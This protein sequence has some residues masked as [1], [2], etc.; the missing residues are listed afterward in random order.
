[1]GYTLAVI[2]RGVGMRP[3]E[4]EVANRRLAGAESFT[5]APSKYLGHYVAGKLAARQGIAVTL[6]GTGSEGAAPLVPATDGGVTATI[7]IPAELVTAA[8]PRPTE[9]PPTPHQEP[10]PAPQE[11]TRTTA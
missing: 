1:M 11:P 10:A 8:P 5:I 9:A 7:S 3:A 4:L 2:D 6:H